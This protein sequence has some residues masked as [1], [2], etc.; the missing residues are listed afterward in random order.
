MRIL[1]PS[2]IPA[3]V[4]HQPLFI[5]ESSMQPL[6]DK[7]ISQDFWSCLRHWSPGT[8][9]KLHAHSSD[10]LIIITGGKGL[11]TTEKEAV[12]VVTGEIV[13]IPAGEK[14]WHGATKE[15]GVA[16]IQIQSGDSQTTQFEQ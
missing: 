3:E 7:G 6:I 4:Q 11:M 2:E 12:A 13:F 9:A 5:G 15:M 14:H 1:R 8:R 16:Y 10:Q